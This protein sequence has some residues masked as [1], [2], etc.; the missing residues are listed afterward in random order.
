MDG[1][2]NDA[3]GPAGGKYAGMVPTTG[4]EDGW[5]AGAVGCTAGIEDGWVVGAVGCCEDEGGVFCN[6]VTLGAEVEPEWFRPVTDGAACTGGGTG[7]L[8]G[9]DVVVDDGCTV[10]K[11]GGAAAE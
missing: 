10:V 5:A 7:A 6:G 2:M 4:I 9:I 8:N 1:G 3:G 11:D